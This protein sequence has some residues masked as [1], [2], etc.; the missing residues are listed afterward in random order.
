MNKVAIKQYALV[1]RRRDRS[2][3]A[4]LQ[5]ERFCVAQLNATE[6]LPTL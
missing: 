1:C 3:P 6:R 5:N 2:E 4:R